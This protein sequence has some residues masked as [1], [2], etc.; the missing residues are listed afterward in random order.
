[1]DTADSWKLP[2]G[3][4]EVEVLEV[5]SQFVEGFTLSLVIRIVLET[6]DPTAVFF[7]VSDL[8]HVHQKNLGIRNPST[9]EAARPLD[10]SEP[11]PK[12]KPAPKR[13]R[14]ALPSQKVKRAQWRP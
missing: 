11:R 9:L 8:G 4:V 1:M 6:A 10:E 13:P 2:T 5:S 3:E 12:W 14:Q 7:P